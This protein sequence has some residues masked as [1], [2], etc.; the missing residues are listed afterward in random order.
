MGG[1]IWDLFTKEQAIK[2]EMIQYQITPTSIPD[3]RTE[4]FRSEALLDL[5][6]AIDG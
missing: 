3:G 1:T 2:D 6:E 4:C 5:C